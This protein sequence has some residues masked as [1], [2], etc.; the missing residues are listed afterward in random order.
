MNGTA[1][2]KHHKKSALNPRRTSFGTYLMFVHNHFTCVCVSLWACKNRSF[3]NVADVIDST[4]WDHLFRKRPAAR[5]DD[6]E[7]NDCGM[8]AVGGSVILESHCKY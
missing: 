1:V 6:L 4:Y 7:I 8:F 2:C 3:D 5:S